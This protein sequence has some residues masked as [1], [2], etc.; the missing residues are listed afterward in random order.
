MFNF[1]NNKLTI[2]F[3]SVEIQKM[4][5]FRKPIYDSGYYNSFYGGD[6]YN[7]PINRDCY[8]PQIQGLKL[9]VLIYQET[10]QDRIFINNLAYNRN[11][12]FGDIVKT[13]HAFSYV[14][15]QG[16]H[17]LPILI[18]HKNELVSN[19]AWILSKYF[20]NKSKSE[21]IVKVVS[22]YHGLG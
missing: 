20:S 22:K 3:P 19:W 9:E 1:E 7:S 5:M 17:R 8:M 2:T 4:E 21:E 18:K 16:F 6:T 15:N 10:D 13:I 11:D 14:I 12:L